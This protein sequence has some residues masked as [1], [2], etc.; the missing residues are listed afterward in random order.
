[1]LFLVFK[2]Q[3]MNSDVGILGYNLWIHLCWR[4]NLHPAGFHPAGIQPES[5]RF[6]EVNLQ[7]TGY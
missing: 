3:K 1:M 5:N 7:I 4:W 2:N 6:L